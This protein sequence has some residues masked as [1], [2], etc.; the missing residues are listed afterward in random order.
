MAG[1]LRCW[2]EEILYQRIHGNF[3]FAPRA[4]RLVEPGALPCPALLAYDLPHPSELRGH[5]LV[6]GNNLIKRVC[7]FSRQSD[8]GAWEPHGEV[9]IADSL[10]ISQ[11][12]FEISVG[13]LSKGNVS[14]FF[15]ALQA[16]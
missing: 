16:P 14:I 7:N 2:P 1:D 13:M 10:Q 6:G 12:H 4:S 9:S 15:A 3:H 11:D 8:P 5:L